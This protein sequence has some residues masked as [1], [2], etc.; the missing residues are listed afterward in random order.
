MDLNKVLLCVDLVREGAKISKTH[1]KT[2][3]K[4]SKYEY[5]G[6]TSKT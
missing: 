6:T 4:I 3:Q 2:F 5:L 1:K